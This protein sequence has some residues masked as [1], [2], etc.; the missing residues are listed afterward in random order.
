MLRAPTPI[1]VHFD[2]KRIVREI[3]AS[4]LTQTD[5]ANMVGADQS[6][7]SQLRS[8]ARKDTSSSIGLRLLVL[9]EQRMAALRAAAPSGAQ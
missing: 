4:E 1:P 3:E 2:W 5:I 7:I 6:T 8:G 9:H